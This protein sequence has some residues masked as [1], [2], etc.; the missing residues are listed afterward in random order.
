M[1]LWAI[2]ITRIVLAA[3]RPSLLVSTKALLRLELLWSACDA[4]DKAILWQRP[5]LKDLCVVLKDNTLVLTLDFPDARVGDPVV[6]SL[7][8]VTFL[9]GLVLFFACLAGPFLFG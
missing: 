4:T 9:D 2:D 6:R 7:Q 1:D 8:G 3:S 5:L